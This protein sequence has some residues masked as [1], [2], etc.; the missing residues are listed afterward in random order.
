MPSVHGASAGAHPAA[1]PVKAAS[2]C[3]PQVAK[4]S[5][6]TAIASV[7]LMLPWFARP[8]AWQI[9]DRLVGITM[10]VLSVSLARYVINGI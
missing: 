2:A 6:F 10:W 5:A 9:L 7:T 4:L 8:R 1:C 3:M